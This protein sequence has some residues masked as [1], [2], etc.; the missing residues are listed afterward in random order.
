MDRSG[1]G[2]G[3]DWEV[4]YLC[5]YSKFDSWTGQVSSDYVK[6]DLCSDVM[7]TQRS[8][9]N[10]CRR[11]RGCVSENGKYANMTA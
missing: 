2:D 9:R 3:V 11:C 6:M 7:H 10:I 8:I 5:M 1:F 4:R